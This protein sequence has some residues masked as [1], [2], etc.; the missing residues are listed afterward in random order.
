M[1]VSYTDVF[2]E[3]VSAEHHP[4]SLR[5]VVI[6]REG[7]MLL[8]IKGDYGTYSVL[9]K[10]IGHYFTGRDGDV[11]AQWAQMG[12][13]FIGVWVEAGDDW[14]F[15]FRLPAKRMAR[16][17]CGLALRGS[18]APAIRPRSAASWASAARR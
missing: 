12:A 13:V 17:S 11:T 8:E 5:G 9:G 3:F 7:E 14:F 16:N 4:E 18:L 15:R 6:D 10:R 2:F 1:P